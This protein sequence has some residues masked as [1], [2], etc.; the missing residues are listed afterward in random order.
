[1]F[2]ASLLCVARQEV[3]VARH[4]QGTPP[5]GFCVA[6][7]WADPGELCCLR[8]RANGVRAGVEKNS[9]TGGKS[10]PPELGREW[11]FCDSTPR[12]T[13]LPAP[14][15]F[16]VLSIWGHDW[17]NPEEQIL[18]SP[19]GAAPLLTQSC[20][21]VDSA[22][23]SCPSHSQGW[24]SRVKNAFQ[25]PLAPSLTQISSTLFFPPNSLQL[26]LVLLLD[27]STGLQFSLEHLPTFLTKRI[28]TSSIFIASMFSSVFGSN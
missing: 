22:A 21:K 28:F 11:G 17:Q 4:P 16:T 5:P 26:F 3:A 15:I 23:S 10:S 19:R 1:M 9:V 25:C 20:S 6:W 27:F 24:V 8:G 18:G 7:A 2:P 14:N 12:E 13:A